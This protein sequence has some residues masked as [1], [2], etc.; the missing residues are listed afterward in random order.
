MLVQ[1]FDYHLPPELIAQEPLAN[2]AASRMLVVYRKEGRWE[3]RQFRDFPAFVR[4]GDCLVVN[5]SKV[6][7]ARL[8]GHR[9]GHTGHVEVLLVEPR[10]DDELTWL[11]LA[12]PGK[13][14]RTGDTIVF[15]DRVRATILG[16]G[17][18]GERL[19]RFT[20]SGNFYEALQEVGHI[21]LPPY[22]N[23]ADTVADRNRYQTVYAANAGSVAAPTAGLHFTPEVLQA[24]HEAGAAIAHVTLHVGLGT[25]QPLQ[26]DVVEEVKLHE[27]RYSVSAAVAEQLRAAPRVIAIGTTSVRTVETVAASNWQQLTGSTSIFLYPGHRFARVDALLT[28]FHLPKSSLL[29]LVCALGGTELMLAAYR[30]AVEQRYR[31]FSYGD[32][33]L[34]V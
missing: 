23:R 15:S 19:L 32:C 12:R 27:E 22:I 33:M 4:A 28:N 9:E 25:F 20:A 2:R 26:T 1:D 11:A 29:M 5:D 21:P 18:R 10:S 24:C 16:R 31:F 8:Y 7:P 17:E 3:D 13:K 34:I 6:I 30:H 14:L